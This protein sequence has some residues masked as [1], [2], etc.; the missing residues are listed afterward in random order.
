MSLLPLERTRDMVDRPAPAPLAAPSPVEVFDASVDRDRHSGRE[1]VR[2]RVLAMRPEDTQLS[3]MWG[4]LPTPS[5]AFWGVRGE[6]G[7]TLALR[8]DSFS[9]PLAARHDALEVL[10]RASR[11]QMVPVIDGESGHRSFW[12]LLDNRVVLV[13]AQASRTARRSTVSLLRRT[14]ARMP[15]ESLSE[16]NS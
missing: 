12:A 15:H 2:A 3:L 1:L 14:L 4:P 6:N 8:A 11:M 5:H 10:S 9:S 7:L 16:R 13:G